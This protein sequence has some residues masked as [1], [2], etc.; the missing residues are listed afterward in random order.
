[1]IY[2]Q[3]AGGRDAGCGMRVARCGMRFASCELRV[4]G[5][6]KERLKAERHSVFGFRD[7]GCG[8]AGLKAQRF[9]LVAERRTDLNR[10]GV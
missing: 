5:Y 9:L 1:M 4:A 3:D 7:A 10:R 2:E 6:G 8:M